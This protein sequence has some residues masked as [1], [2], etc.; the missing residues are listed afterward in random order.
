MG[1]TFSYYYERFD[2]KDWAAINLPG[3]ELPRIDYL[4]EISMGY[5]N[6]PYRGSTGYFRVFY[7]F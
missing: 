7:L 5:S 2:V 1:V 3:T 6:R 4:G